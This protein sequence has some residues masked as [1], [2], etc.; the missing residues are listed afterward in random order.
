MLGAHP[1]LRHAVPDPP[2]LADDV[3]FV[4]HPLPRRDLGDPYV[5]FD[6]SE[7]LPVWGQGGRG[8]G[9]MALFES[10]V[11]SEGMEQAGAYRTG[12][13]LSLLAAG[14]RGGLPDVGGFALAVKS[15]AFLVRTVSDAVVFRGAGNLVAAEAGVSR[16]RAALEGS[17]ELRFA[18]GRSVTPSVELGVRQDGGDA[19]TGT[20]LETGFRGGLR[21]PEPLPDDGC[22]AQPPGGAPG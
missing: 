12:S 11:R 5:A 20:R 4:L 14:V 9:E 2:H 21:R 8:R 3:C 22:H 15:D 10:L 1:G 6:L 16:V 17:R 7:D 18:G 19:E 13:G